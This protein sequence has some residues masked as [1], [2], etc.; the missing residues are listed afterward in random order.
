[1]KQ[2]NTM[3]RRASWTK[4]SSNTSSTGTEKPAWLN[5]DIRPK[6]N[7][8][9][10]YCNWNNVKWFWCSHETG[11]KCPGKWCVHNS[12]DCKG[13]TSNSDQQKLKVNKGVTKRNADALKIAT[14]K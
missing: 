9:T 3:A 8:I 1:M 6:D 5:K 7:S 11:G 12:G 14:A 13:I 10:K 4:I 2:R